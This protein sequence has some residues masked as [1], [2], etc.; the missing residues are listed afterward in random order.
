M[1][2]SRDRVAVLA[3]VLAAATACAPTPTTPL[4]EAA[5]QARQVLGA[6]IQ[7]FQDLDPTTASKADYRSA[8]LAVREAFFTFRDIGY[9]VADENVTALNQ[10]IDDLEEAIEDLPDDTDLSDAVATLEP[11]LGAVAAALE[12]MDADLDCPE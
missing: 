3:L 4:A 6:T 12:A 2:T 1:T 7:E 5:C 8:A 10:A 11:H 9:E